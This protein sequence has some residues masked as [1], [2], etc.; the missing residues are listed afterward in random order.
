MP[1]E[2]NYKHNIPSPLNH[3]EE[4]L[5]IL[6]SIKENLTSYTPSLPLSHSTKLNGNKLK[7]KKGKGKFNISPSPSVMEVANINNYDNNKKFEIFDLKDN[8]KTYPLYLRCL[9][10][11][12]RQFFLR[13]TKEVL[14][15]EEFQE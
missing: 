10:I 4:E 6:D 1:V 3:K 12:E 15:H 9:I 8:I 14:T 2:V 7:L 11:I 13:E 5:K